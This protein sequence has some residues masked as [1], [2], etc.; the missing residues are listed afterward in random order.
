MFFSYGSYVTLECT[1][2]I[3]D[4]IVHYMMAY[5]HSSTHCHTHALVHTLTHSF[6]PQVTNSH[7]MMHSYN[8]T[9]MSTIYTPLSLSSPGNVAHT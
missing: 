3:H 1:L 8:N 7:K 6:T 9:H 2:F 5:I 4:N